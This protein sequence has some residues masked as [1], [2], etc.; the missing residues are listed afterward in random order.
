LLD[1]LDDNSILRAYDENNGAPIAL[2][3]AHAIGLADE[4]AS[5]GVCAERLSRE[6]AEFC[7]QGGCVAHR[8]FFWLHRLSG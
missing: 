5:P 7:Q 1:P 2:S 3:Y 4:W 6:G 8:H